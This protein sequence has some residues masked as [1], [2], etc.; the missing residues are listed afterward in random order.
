MPTHPQW[1]K[2]Y[3][4]RCNTAK[5]PEEFNHNRAT[6]DGLQAWCRECQSE[7]GNV[8]KKN[9]EEHT[10]GINGEGKVCKKCHQFKLLHLYHN[11]KYGKFG[12]AD[13]CIECAKKEKRRYR[14]ILA[15]RCSTLPKAKDLPGALIKVNGSAIRKLRESAHYTIPQLLKKLGF[16]FVPAEQ[17]WFS[18]MELD[19]RNEVPLAFVEKL[20]EAFD[21]PVDAFVDGNAF[22][23]ACKYDP[24]TDAVVKVD[25]S[26][27]QPESSGAGAINE[28]IEQMKATERQKTITEIIEYLNTLIV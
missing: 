26:T 2:K 25:V 28:I 23:V 4:T 10:I 14:N 3:C 19:K 20:A 11:N 24:F 9:Y 6:S 27:K 7:Y 1:A 17:T 16:S 21:L 22:Q 13:Q 8:Y 5:S 15:D 12:K 18:S